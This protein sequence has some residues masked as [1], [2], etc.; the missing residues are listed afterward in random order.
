MKPR[1]RKFL[2]GLL[3]LG[4]L[5]QAA[6]PL[7]A[8][9]D[10]GSGTAPG[11]T[12]T[13]GS[14]TYNMTVD[15]NGQV[16]VPTEWTEKA[17][18][19]YPT[20]P[21]VS[22]RA[23]TG[24]VFSGC[25]KVDS[26]SI[27]GNGS[28]DVTLDGSN[29]CVAMTASAGD[30]TGDGLVISKVQNVTI[31]SSTNYPLVRGSVSI[32]ASGNVDIQNN[33]TS[34]SDL[35]ACISQNLTVETPGTVTVFSNKAP[36]VAKKVTV[37]NA[38]FVDLR[39]NSSYGVIG[40]SRNEGSA[41]FDSCGSVAISN[42][43]PYNGGEARAIYS[44]L[45]APLTVT[46]DTDVVYSAKSSSSGSYT[47][48]EDASA[49]KNYRYFNIDFASAS[50][51]CN[52]TVNGL[53]VTMGNRGNI[54]GTGLVFTPADA[55]NPGAG[56][57]LTTTKDLGGTLTIVVSG[58]AEHKVALNLNH[59]VKGVYS[60]YGS[61]TA[62]AVTGASDVTL[63]GYIGEAVSGT[64]TDLVVLT[65][66]SGTLTYR[67]AAAENR[68]YSV[69]NGGIYVSPADQPDTYTLEMDST[70]TVQLGLGSPSYVN[71]DYGKAYADADCTKP[72]YSTGAAPGSIVYLKANAAGTNQKFYKWEPL[73]GSGN[74]LKEKDLTVVDADAGIYCF[75]VSGTGN[76]GNYNAQAVYSYGF[77]VQTD[78]T[79]GTP[80]V[81]VTTANITSIAGEE[82]LSYDVT[83]NKLKIGSLRNAS[84]TVTVDS[85][86]NDTLDVEGDEITDVVA[87]ANK[88][89]TVTGARNVT[90]KN[91]NC[92]AEL[93]ITGNVT[94]G[95]ADASSSAVRGPINIKNAKDVTLIHNGVRYASTLG[96]I[97]CSGNVNLTSSYG[98][99]GENYASYSITTTDGNVT[100]TGAVSGTADITCKNLTIDGTGTAS[101]REDV[102]GTLYY[103]GPFTILRGGADSSTRDYLA[104]TKNGYIT[105]KGGSSSDG[106]YIR[107]ITTSDEKP[108]T[109][110]LGRDVSFAAGDRSGTERYDHERVSVTADSSDTSRTLKRFVFT[111]SDDNQ[112]ITSALLNAMELSYSDDGY[113]VS[114]YMLNRG[115]TVSAEYTNLPKHTVTLP[116]DGG[117][118][119][120]GD[121]GNGGF[122]PSQPV[123]IKAAETD[124]ADASKVFDRFVFERTST[125]D[126]TPLT[127][128]EL[129]ALDPKPDPS[130]KTKV[131][132]LMPD[133][134]LSIKV[135]YTAL[136]SYGFTVNGVD[137]NAS[138]L[139]T[140]LSYADG[141]LTAST[142]YNGALEIEVT[143]P[144]LKLD[145]DL[146]SVRGALTLTKVNDVTITGTVT[147][148][149]TVGTE[150][151]PI[152]GGVTVSGKIKSDTKINCA[153]D[154]LLENDS[155][156]ATAGLLVW[157]ARDVTV[158][159]SCANASAIS[160]G[161]LITC[162]GTVDLE[163]TSPSGV[164]AIG[165]NCKLTYI[166]A[167]G[168]SYTV[169]LD[170]ADAVISSESSYTHQNS[171]ENEVKHILITPASSGG[172]TD[173]GDN[174]NPGGDTGSSSGSGSDG[175][176]N[177]GGAAA[178]AIV[179]GAAVWG[180]YQVATRI[181]LKNILP[182][183][184]DIP[185][186][187]GQ[188]ALLVW[189]AAGRP[190]PAAAPAFTDVAD[191]D[192]AKAAQ[193]CAEQGYLDAKTES[194]FKPNGLVTKVKVIE[195]WNA[196][197]PKQ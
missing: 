9:A 196:A 124:P 133:Y 157:G 15:D 171:K 149:L 145:V 69:K 190:E 74:S 64:P 67:K 25:F 49:C 160:G 151:T 112:E 189:N 169:K 144:T 105:L 146:K 68:L 114:F 53:A 2:A 176:G 48:V 130:D 161:V 23:D 70:K 31:K 40:D 170:D 158:R 136:E 153:G 132:I 109:L 174:T 152:S 162:S 28:E 22:Y 123:T 82:T 89:L 118:T 84:L 52:I 32:T 159:A 179:G 14:A 33:Y 44:S 57:T 47:V 115:L 26:L 154:I 78:R 119:L 51:Q 54:G 42:I 113:T 30:M 8:L 97:K 135:V 134:D 148:T 19:T 5:L 101:P 66:C 59:A 166:P 111:G 195:V 94:F 10:S 88:K 4:L 182:A 167:N 45:A 163:N 120:E 191:A 181:I 104:S 177:T 85:D 137:A 156:Y 29:F 79:A 147:G 141:K 34:S 102:V 194:T 98:F 103:T 175:L 183:G 75:T 108:H 72:I 121:T 185:T 100:V 173:P 16:T 80:A 93:D 58:A 168:G 46:P 63:N 27:T 41:E 91:L 60:P 87:N 180:G 65:N 18:A 197:F 24:F 81:E 7:S 187:R 20:L 21:T 83:N 192:T 6:S 56:G 12:V 39:A 3:S 36:A 172:S 155:N 38:S 71:L 131:T 73:S 96:S 35:H 122:Y 140:G 43:Y 90:V 77:T 188:L 92:A 165:S 13:A 86:V 150:T 37:R 143:S 95:D 193:W 110:T 61:N 139:P 129:A 186:T 11:L 117:V 116:A 164:R 128:E 106:T 1:I 125:P 184:A 107:Y 99:A 126:N 142:D 62:L 55:S 127:D 178:A 138:T 17:T 76:T 50:S